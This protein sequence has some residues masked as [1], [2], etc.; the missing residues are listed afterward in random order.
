[1]GC[2]L[3]LALVGATAARKSAA[4]PPETM[5]ARSQTCREDGLGKQ[6]EEA[7]EGV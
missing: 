4:G 3:R 5:L 1:M 2:R 7:Q 6:D